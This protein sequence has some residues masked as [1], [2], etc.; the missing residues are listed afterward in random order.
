MRSNLEK[1][2]HIVVLMLENRSFDNLLGWLGTKGRKKQYV[3]GVAGKR[4]ANPIPPYADHPKGKTSIPVGKSSVTTNPNPDPGEGYTHANTQLYGIVNPDKNRFAPFNLKP[5]NLPSDGKLPRTA[6]MTGFVTDYINNF[7]AVRQRSPI[8]K[9]YKIIMDCLD[10]R[11]LPVLTTLAREYAVF[12]AWYSS[13]PSET[14][15]NRAFVHA[16]TSNGGVTNAPFYHWVMHD[17]TTIFEQIQ[18]KDDPKVTWKVYFD[19]LDLIW[20]AGLVFPSL[21][22]YHGT[23]I[24]YMEDFESDAASGNLPS[25]S[26]IEPRL[27]ID[28]ND[29]HPPSAEDPGGTSSLLAGELLIHQVYRALRTGKNWERTLLIITFDEHG[30]CYD[31]VPPPSTV[32]PDPKKAVG[33]YDFKFDRLG[34][35]VPTV[36][37]SPYIKK[38]TVVSDVYDHT[39]ILRTICKRWDLKPLTER[40]RSAKSFEKVLNSRKVR[41]DSPKIKPRRYRVPERAREEPLND[42]QRTILYFV[43]GYDEALKIERDGNLLRMAE[44]LFRLVQ[45]EGRIAHIKTTGQ[46]IAFI[47]SFAQERRTHSPR[48]HFLKHQWNTLKRI[49]RPHSHSD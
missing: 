38:G 33:Q 28:H 22:K 16:G 2:D 24:K 15:C 48:R 17:T 37:I 39:S 42:L 45:A 36:M 20:I 29:A 23:K 34:V 13:V 11:T 35:R 43:A 32:P 46:A 12:D 49:F 5:Y 47:K 8:F 3:N 31:H 10:E 6:P 19:K 27:F 9:E 7:T 14:F 1:I 30:G 18:E 21:W 41:T 4:L 25:Y 44:D 26:F 40:D